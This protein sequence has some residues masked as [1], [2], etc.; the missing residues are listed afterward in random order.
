MSINRNK[1]EDLRRTIEE[2]NIRTKPIDGKN[3]L[4][5][6]EY[7]SAAIIDELL[8]NGA[9]FE[10]FL[11]YRKKSAVNAHLGHLKQVHGIPIKRKGKTY[12]YD[13][14]VT[15]QIQKDDLE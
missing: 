1:I 4:G 2:S 9:T 6:G 7:T 11:K 13:F 10:E 5:H 8:I 14:D 15:P 12:K 3:W